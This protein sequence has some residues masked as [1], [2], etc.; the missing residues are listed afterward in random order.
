MSSYACLGHLYEIGGPGLTKDESAA[1]GW[2]RRGAEAGNAASQNNL[3]LCYYNGTGVTKNLAAARSWF[4]RAVGGTR[5][6]RRSSSSSSSSTG[7]GTGTTGNGKCGKGEWSTEDGSGAAN[8]NNGHN[9]GGGGDGENENDY[10]DDDYDCSGSGSGGGS[11]GS[12]IAEAADLGLCLRLAAMLAAGES[13]PRDLNRA[14]AIW[15]ALAA[16]RG[17]GAAR[18]NLDR[19]HDWLDVP[20][21]FQRAP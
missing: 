7:T 8:G 2:Y 13:G 14:C 17:V 9:G 12:V 15:E 21:Q 5:R 18:A 19:L 20:N 6:R 11:G 3:G 16:E 4:E 1:V 10:D